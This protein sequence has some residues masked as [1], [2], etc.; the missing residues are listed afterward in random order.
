AIRPMPAIT[1]IHAR[2]ATPLR[3]GGACVG[4]CGATG[5]AAHMAARGGGVG[6]TIGRGDAWA[7]GSASKGDSL[8]AAMG[9][10]G[11]AGVGEGAGAGAGAGVGAAS[12]DGR[13]ADVSA[14]FVSGENDPSGIVAGALESSTRSS[15][16]VGDRTVASASARNDRG[17][18]VA[19][20]PA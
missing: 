7:G 3:A 16:R 5:G 14:G 10:D 20:A 13:G 11:A 19:D 15:K 8:V 6:A 9:N 2:V 1:S 17:D 18:E 4:A 12:G